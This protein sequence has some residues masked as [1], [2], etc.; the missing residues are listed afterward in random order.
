MF[1]VFF[2]ALKDY[3]KFVVHCRINNKTKSSMCPGEIVC[4][5]AECFQQTEAQL[6][7]ADISHLEDEFVVELKQNGE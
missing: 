5:S 1:V 2:C 3:I 4:P 6:V 7:S